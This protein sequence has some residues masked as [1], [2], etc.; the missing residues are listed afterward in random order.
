MKNLDELLQVE[1]SLYLN[2]PVPD[3]IRHKAYKTVAELPNRRK[4]LPMWI[5]SIAACFALILLTSSMLH[6][7]FFKKAASAIEYVLLNTPR[8]PNARLLDDK[9]RPVGKNTLVTNDYHPIIFSVKDKSGFF[10]KA[11][12]LGGSKAGK[13]YTIDDFEI[14]GKYTKPED[15][16]QTINEKNYVDIDLIKGDETF[17][18][19]SSKEYVSKSKI[20]KPILTIPGSTLSKVLDVDINS[21]QAA[22]DVLIGING[23]WNGIPRAITQNTDKDSTFIR[24]EGDNPSKYYLVNRNTKSDGTIDEAISLGFGSKIY[25]IDNITIDGTYTSGC[26]LFLLD[27]D[28]DLKEEPVVVTYGHNI[29]VSAYKMDGTKAEKVLSYYEGD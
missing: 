24:L 9:T 12:V 16:N 28:G 3:T 27:I 19:Y 21:L 6:F 14:K 4:P 15:F 18:F 7:G 11:K 22:D 20:S 10:S 26:A 25:P 8:N 13:W 17:K 29:S 1:K 23:Q 5:K 2:T